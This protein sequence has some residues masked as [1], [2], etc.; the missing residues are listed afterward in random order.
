MENSQI[1]FLEKERLLAENA[2][3]YTKYLIATKDYLFAI[4]TANTFKNKMII[5]SDDAPL[6]ELTFLIGLA[7][8]YLNDTDS[9]LLNFKTAF[10]SAHSIGSCY[11]TICK[12]YLT[13]T[14]QFPLPEGLLSIP[15]IPLVFYDEK[16]VIDS[17]NFSDGTLQPDIALAQTLL[18]R[19]G[20]SDTAFTF[21]GNAHETD[22]QNLLLKLKS[23]P[24][25]ESE[26]ILK[27]SNEMYALCTSKD[28]LYLQYAT[29]K[30]ANSQF[31]NSENLTELLQA[32]SFTLPDFHFDELNKYRL[33]WLELTILNNYCTAQCQLQ[34]SKGI[35][36]FYKLLDYY[37]A[38]PIDILEKRR[39]FA[40][41][42]GVLIR[43]LFDQHRY[44]EIIDLN[45]HFSSS[46]LKCS[47]NFTGLVYSHYA[48]SLGKLQK[49]N[50]AALYA[51]YSYYNLQIVGLVQQANSFKNA[52]NNDFHILL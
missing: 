38:I 40:V 31:D 1:F 24:F 51:N 23:L 29:Y 39:F 14:I 36:L 18:Q 46:T 17:S 44:T 7:H 25:S 6:H 12:N 45:N 10:F 2:I 37:D 42:L 48:Q 11:A 9:A 47:L 26:S 19:L 13:S 15:E 20:I 21:F 4:K 16:K 35:L 22:L 8:Y 27:Y 49:T 5:N 52:I 28:L 30:K 33:S 43:C 32:L 41:T 3:V 34:P 50:L